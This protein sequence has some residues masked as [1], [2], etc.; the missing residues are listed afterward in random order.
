MS[1]LVLRV[2]SGI[3]ASHPELVG[4]SAHHACRSRPVEHFR[5]SVDAGTLIETRV[6]GQ[7]QVAPF[8]RAG[9]EHGVQPSFRLGLVPVERFAVS[10]REH[11]DILLRRSVGVASQVRPIVPHVGGGL[12]GI[13]TVGADGVQNLAA[14]LCDVRHAVR[15]AIACRGVVDRLLQFVEP[16]LPERVHEVLASLQA[17]V[18]QLFP[19]ASVPHDMFLFRLRRAPGVALRIVEQRRSGKLP[20]FALQRHGSR[21]RPSSRVSRTGGCGGAVVSPGQCARVDGIVEH[22]NH[23]VHGLLHRCP[24]ITV[25]R[26]VADE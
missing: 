26:F 24:R 21:L 16:V 20:D 7:R 22:L 12:E 3:I 17:V 13:I 5:Q 25:A 10:P 14:V 8:E 11:L 6:T 4:L 23:E 15:P 2:V 18:P 9:H 1:R 19:V